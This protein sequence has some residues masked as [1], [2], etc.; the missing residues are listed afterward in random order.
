MP[1]YNALTDTDL[2]HFALHSDE[3]NV[4][5][6]EFARGSYTST[7][8]ETKTIAHNL[9]YIPFYLV[10]VEVNG[11][12]MSTGY[13]TFQLYIAS[14]VNTANLVIYTYPAINVK[15]YIFYDNFEVP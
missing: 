7:A 13:G 8:G 10:F 6:K 14:G 15:Y 2:D 5:I 9:G 1:G 11:K 3:D 12:W 4:L